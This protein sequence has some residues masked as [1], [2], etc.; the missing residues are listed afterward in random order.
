MR[1]PVTL[2]AICLSTMLLSAC[3]TKRAAEPVPTV[4]TIKAETGPTPAIGTSTTVPS[5]DSVLAPANDTPK[6]EPTAGRSNTRMTR[7]EESSAM[8]M[9]GQNNDHSA[10]VSP[11]KR[12]SSP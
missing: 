7:A 3:D 12:A 4:E 6:P 10:P 2:A 8:P 9:P 11:A 1:S 5:A